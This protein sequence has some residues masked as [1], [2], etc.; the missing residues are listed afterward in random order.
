MNEGR[1]MIDRLPFLLHNRMHLVTVLTLGTHTASFSFDELAI[2]DSS[3]A[4]C[5]VSRSLNFKLTGEFF[6]F[7]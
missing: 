6:P 2:G 5:H 3:K 7:L 1:A 4:M